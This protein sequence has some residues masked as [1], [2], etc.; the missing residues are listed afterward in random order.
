MFVEAFVDGGG[1][2]ADLR[3]MPLQLGH[4]L[5]RG[6]QAGQANVA[7]ACLF[8]PIDRGDG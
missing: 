3:M 4:A 6:E 2:D 5:G 8:Q 1:P 7:G